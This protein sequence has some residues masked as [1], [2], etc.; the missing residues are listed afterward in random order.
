MAADL[1]YYLGGEL[2]FKGGRLAVYF[3]SCLV[4]VVMGEFPVYPVSHNTG[5]VDHQ[6]KDFLMKKEKKMFFFFVFIFSMQR[7]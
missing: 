1:F 5:Y 7:N 2:V 4:D 3:P 6:R